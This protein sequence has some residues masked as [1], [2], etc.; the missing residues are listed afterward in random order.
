M[1]MCNH[2]RVHFHDTTLRDGEQTPGVAFSS[3]VRKEIALK[4]DDLGVDIIE[5]GFAASSE[6]QRLA[7]RAITE[8]GLRAKTLSLV[9]PIK[10]DIDAALEAGVDGVILVIGFSDIHLKY[11]FKKDFSEVVKILRG[12][13]E[14]AKSKGLYV[15]ISTEDGTR[16]SNEKLAV[17]AQLGEKYSVDRFCISDTVGIGTPKIISD[18]VRC[19]LNSCNIPVSVHCHND[20]GLATINSI[21]AVEAGARNLAVTMNGLGERTGNASLEQCAMALTQLYGY[22]TNI[23][24][25][26]L[27]SVSQYISN[28]TEIELEPMRP[29]TGRNCFKHESG[30]HVEA[31]LKNPTCY[32]PY[33]PK[34]IGAKQSLFW[35]KPTVSQRLNISQ[36][37]LMNF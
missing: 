22:E 31:I 21:A 35:A 24:L 27:L 2:E 26:K 12:G 30:I 11:K 34:I 13:L 4:L 33:D 18:K 37:N 29:I 23:N 25:S 5:L 14:Y 15:Q 19:I 10:N 36:E 20:F 9:R 7:M 17:I 28:V 1:I 3:E 16:T 6:D 32:E 8:S